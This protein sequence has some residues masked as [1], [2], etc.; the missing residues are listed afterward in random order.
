MKYIPVIPVLCCHPEPQSSKLAL[1]I[2]SPIKTITFLTWSK[3]HSLRSDALPT[4]DEPIRTNNP[5]PLGQTS[6]TPTNNFFCTN[7]IWKHMFPPTEIWGQHPLGSEA[8]ERNPG[9]SRGISRPP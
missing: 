3:Y 5:D 2:A 8:T 7:K 1:P 9:I 4:T 6:S